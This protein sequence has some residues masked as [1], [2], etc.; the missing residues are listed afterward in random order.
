MRGDGWLRLRG[1]VYYAV[2]YHRGRKRIESL[3]TSDEATAERRLLALRKKREKGDYQRPAER[4]V[5]VSDLLD[6]LL[7]NLEV[8]G[9]ASLAKMRSHSKAVREEIGH[10][11]ARDVTSDMV[12]QMALR[13][14][15][16]GAA[17]ATVN[18]RLEA[19]GRAYRIALRKT[20]PKVTAIPYFQLLPVDNVRRGFFERAELDRL[21]P[22]LDSDLADF[23]AWC[24]V[25]GMRKGEASA[26]TFAM[27]DRTATP[28][29]LAIPAS[30]CKNREG[31]VVPVVGTAREVIERRLAARRLD[32]PL[33]FHRR[34]RGRDGRPVLAFDKAWRAALRAAGL[35][36]DRLFHDLRRSAARNLTRAGASVRQAMRVTGHKT[37]SMFERYNILTDEDAADALEKQDAA[38]GKKR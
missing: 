16:V 35:P 12:D 34:S 21:L 25:V 8:R 10:E 22:H 31:R 36:Q 30:L 26:L 20:P 15:R 9:L 13:W 11:Q 28:W 29:T 18:R 1:G 32:T 23:T 7:S 5:T 3:R 37:A 24:Y 33:I 2:F 27:L 17:R 4:R 6:D 19:L 38:Q 14:L